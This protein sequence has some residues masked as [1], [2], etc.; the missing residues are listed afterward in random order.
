MATSRSNANSILRAMKDKRLKLTPLSERDLET[1]PKPKFLN[2]LESHVKRE[3]QYRSIPLEG[4]SYDRLQIYRETFDYLIEAFRTYRPLLAAI[5]REYEMM[6]QYYVERINKL[7]PLKEQLYTFANECDYKIVQIREAEKD[8]KYHNFLFGVTRNELFVL[9]A[10][11]I[12][13]TVQDY[14]YI[15]F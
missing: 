14:Q 4:V 8:G 9:D 3:I 2:F 1:H 5:K 12:I 15:F 11:K 7:E 6:L 10:N 13:L